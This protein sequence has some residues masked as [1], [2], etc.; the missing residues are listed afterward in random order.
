MHDKMK[1]VF[2]VTDGK[3]LDPAAGKARL[4]F[5]SIPFLFFFLKGDHDR[6]DQLVVPY[7]PSFLPELNLPGMGFEE[8]ELRSQPIKTNATTHE[9]PTPLF[10]GSSNFASESSMSAGGGSLRLNIPPSEDEFMMQQQDDAGRRDP[11]PPPFADE[12][13]VLLQADFEFDEDGNII[14]LAGSDHH[15]HAWEGQVDDYEITTP[16]VANREHVVGHVPN[17]SDPPVSLIRFII[18]SAS[19]VW[20]VVLDDG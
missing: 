11:P 16:A 20:L 14:E 13:G 7:D 17:F 2:K 19:D 4:V 1:S 18:V 12:E 10:T 8:V 6:P 3:G 5:L 15:H 9:E